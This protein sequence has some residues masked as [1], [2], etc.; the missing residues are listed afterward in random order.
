MTAVL[1]Y[2]ERIDARAAAIARERY[3]CLTP[4]Q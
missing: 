1:R 3:G 2:L 4:W